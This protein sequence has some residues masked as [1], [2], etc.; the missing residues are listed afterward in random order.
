[1]MEIIVFLMEGR[2]C[3]GATFA[4]FDAYR[5]LLEYLADKMMIPIDILL[6]PTIDVIVI[7]RRVRHPWFHFRLVEVVLVVRW[8]EGKNA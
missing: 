1:M 5:Y 6:K 2:E 8:R 3:C 4:T 7:L